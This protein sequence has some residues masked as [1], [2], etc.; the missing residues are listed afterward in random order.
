MMKNL[1]CLFQWAAP[2]LLLFSVFVLAGPAFSE[3]DSSKAMEKAAGFLSA[4]QIELAARALEG[5]RTAFADAGG[6]KRRLI[7][8]L[9]KLR[10]LEEEGADDSSLSAE[11]MES[12]FLLAARLGNLEAVRYYIKTGADPDIQ[13]KEDGLTALHYALQ[14]ARPETAIQDKGAGRTAFHYALPGAH[15]ETAGFLLESGADPDIQ[16]KYGSAVIHWASWLG[17]AWWTERLLEDGANPDIRDQAGET[18]LHL[19]YHHAQIAA[20]LLEGGADPNIRSKTGQTALY[21]AARAGNAETAALLLEGGADPNI[22]DDES[23][24]TALH[25]VMRI[26]HEKKRRKQRRFCWR[27]ALIQTFGAKP[28]RQLFTLPQIYGMQGR[29]LSFF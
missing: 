12:L 19:A 29:Q 2:R 9:K 15:A 27:A 26:G 22:P 14:G 11:Q 8:A 1:F 28:A 24:W 7:S 3:K 18:A 25:S 21:L 16:T 6:E 4:G 23:G 20:L 5:R 10:G 13:D 17:D